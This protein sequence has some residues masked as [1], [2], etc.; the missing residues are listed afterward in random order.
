MSLISR[1]FGCGPAAARREDSSAS[2]PPR[3]QLV[4]QL[5]LLVRLA[6]RAV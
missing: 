5:V 2:A 4:T 6:L 1:C 3:K